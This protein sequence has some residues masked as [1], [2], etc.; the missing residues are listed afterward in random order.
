MVKS[1]LISLVLSG[2]FLAGSTASAAVFVHAGPVHVAVGRPVGHVHPVYR[3][4][5]VRPIVAAPVIAPRPA[6]VL[7][8]PAITPARVYWHRQAVRHAI[9]ERIEDAVENAAQ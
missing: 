4:V 6:A 5:A 8:P 7:P 2:A 1:L 3:P 9:Q